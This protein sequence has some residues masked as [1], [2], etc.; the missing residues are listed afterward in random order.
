NIDGELKGGLITVRDSKE[1]TTV[2]HEIEHALDV[3]HGKIKKEGSNLTTFG[4]FEHE[5]FASDWLHKATVKQVLA[6]GKPVPPE[7]LADYPD[8]QEKPAVEQ[9]PTESIKVFS[10][11][12]DKQGV[13]N[14]VYENDKGITLSRVVVPREQQKAGIGTKYMNELIEY[15]DDKGKLIVLTPSKDFGATSIS[16]LKSFYKRFGFVENKGKN[17]DLAISESMYRKPVEKVPVTEP[18][19]MPT[20]KVPPSPE[21]DVR[22]GVKFKPKEQGITLK[23]IKEV[24]PTADN[25]GM[26]ADGNYW[27]DIDGRRLKIYTVEQIDADEYKFNI[28]YGRKLKPGEK[29]VGEYADAEIVISKLGDKHTLRHEQY[30]WIEDTSVITGAD[31]KALNKKISRNKGIDVNDVTEEDR[32]QFV[33]DVIRGKEKARSGSHLSR[34]M[35]KIKDWISSL[36]NMFKRTA[37]GVVS[38]IEKG[39]IYGKEKIAKVPGGFKFSNIE[40]EIRYQEALIKDPTLMSRLREQFET[41]GHNISREYEHLPKIG[42]FAQLRFDLLRL[43]K[44]KSIATELIITEMNEVVK[45]LNEDNYALFS[46]KVLIDDLIEVAKEDKKLP[47]GFE[48]EEVFEESKQLDDYIKDNK[49]VNEAVSKRNTMW[50]SIRPK[51]IKA[52]SEI[53]FNVRN[54]MDRKNYMRHQVLDYAQMTNVVGVGKKLKTPAYRSF[55]KQRKG[56]LLDIN[57]DYLQPEF[58]VL[59]QMQYDI[60]IAKVIKAVEKNYSIVNELKVQAIQHNDATIMPVFEELARIESEA[61]VEAGKEPLTAED[62]Y[63]RLLNKK[64]AIGFDKLGKLASQ[65]ALPLGDNYEYADLVDSIAE[66]WLANKGIPAELK[67]PLPESVMKNILKY[68]NWMIKKHG[69]DPGSGAAALIFKGIREKIATMK[70]ILKE[71]YVEWKDLIPE[72]YVTWQPREGNIFYMS[73]TIPSRIAE[74][75]MNSTLETYGLTKDDINK[76]LAIGGKRKEFVVKEEVALTLDNIVRSRSDTKMAKV[77]RELISTW[78]EFQLVQPRR[79]AK[80]NMRNLTGDADGAYAGN[81]R[82]FKK[83]PAAIMDLWKFYTKNEFANENI[84][85]W[86]TR[87]GSISTLQAQEMREL[88]RLHLFSDQ[89]KKEHSLKHV[90]LNAWKGYWRTARIATDFREAILRYAA[91]LQFLEEANNTPAGEPLP[92]YGASIPEEIDGLADNRDKAYWLANDLLG[93]YDRVGVTGQYLREQWYPFWCVPAETEILTRNGWKHYNEINIGDIALTYSIESRTTNWEE[94]QKIAVFEFDDSL[95]AIKNKRG[96]QFRFTKNH[97]IPVLQKYKNRMKFVEAQNLKTHHFIPLVAEHTDFPQNSIITPKEAALL[98]WIITDGY[99]RERNGSNESM[100]YQSPLKYANLIRE[101]FKEWITSEYVHPDTKV[102]CFRITNKATKNIN[103]YLRDKTLLVS[104]MPM[105]G[106]KSLDALLDAMIKAE[107]HSTKTFTHFTQNDTSVMD[108]FQIGCYL[109]GKGFDI[110]HI[111]TNHLGK[112]EMLGGHV[113]RINKISLYK[114][115]YEEQPYKGKVWCPVTNNGTW[116][117]RQ[118]G[119]VLITGN[120]WKEVNMR[121]YTQMFKNAAN[122]PEI[123]E[124]VGNRFL[125]G[126]IKTPYRAYRIGRFA[127]RASALLAMTYLWNRTVMRDED[128]DLPESVRNKP[129]LTIGRDK[130]GQVIV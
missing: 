45:D 11:K 68:A 52:M 21:R 17:K 105:L 35:Q 33:E 123:A 3:I 63:K 101:Q 94:I 116:I 42:E 124:K 59:A 24:F 67:T 32:A 115:R 49:K 114:W 70:D 74:Q 95:V 88:K 25:M 92:N 107:A 27:V 56:S 73:D 97:R 6:E 129:H 34:I 31:I 65:G 23:D 79:F 26:D 28:G 81:P 54:M 90:P 20:K 66:N 7:V 118:E 99:Y 41:I 86:Y 83:V 93:A 37:G 80:Y 91:Y 15:A 108:A 89:Y 61:R 125:R 76:A 77:Q 87:G 10:D 60:E 102:I 40:R 8:L 30:H 57:R 18:K 120:S 106:R 112:N 51:Y 127:I 62:V 48:K 113:K 43:K 85:D 47:Y 29:V 16:R 117:M 109:S 19:A 44:Q 38:G 82:V 98:G 111:K 5:T 22:Y 55:L 128:D 58:E 13:V 75:L 1:L 78:K 104:L 50:G 53:G 110:R 126:A 14:D 130:D 84:K 122:S 119:R 2:R 72:G 46:R 96:H 12:W 100:I 9:K 71:D 103:K 36:I 39:T 64:Q 121:K 4:R 69:G